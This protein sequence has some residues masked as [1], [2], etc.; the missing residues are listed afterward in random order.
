MGPFAG[1]WVKDA[2]PGIVE[3]LRA[4]GRLLREERYLH[5]YPHCWRCGTP[6][7]YYAKPSWYI[8]TS[9]VRDQMVA[10]NEKINWYPD[11][12]KHGRFGKWLEN[13]VD[14]ALS[15]ERYWGTPLP[16][17]RCDEGHEHAIGSLTELSDL[18]RRDVTGIDPHRPAIDEVMV[19]CPTC[20]GISTRVPEVIDTW[21][22]P[23][24]MPHA[25]WGYHPERGRG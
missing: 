4:R 12:I 22:D 19:P 15:R 25:Q 21:Y 8:A 23:G 11:H 3:D 5:S 18:A 9:Q 7:I 2:D 24:A 20:G 1:R 10:E 16:I 13:N 14:W 17:W 6:L